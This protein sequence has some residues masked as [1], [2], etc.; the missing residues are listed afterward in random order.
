MD[1]QEPNKRPIF[2]VVAL[3]APFI[4][5]LGFF[6]LIHFWP[7]DPA[8][9]GALFPGLLLLFSAPLIGVIAAIIS[10]VR[11][12]RLKAWVTAALLVNGLPVISVLAQLLK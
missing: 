7:S 9:F 1:I 3:A 11:K 12:E 5:V 6:A 10:L 8:G 2:G 4:G